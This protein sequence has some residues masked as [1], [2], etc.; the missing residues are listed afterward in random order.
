MNMDNFFFNL[1]K[2]TLNLKKQKQNKQKTNKSKQ[3]Q[4]NILGNNAQKA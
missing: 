1:L 4:S 2:L 3:T